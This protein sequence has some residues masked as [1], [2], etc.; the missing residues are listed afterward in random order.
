M[1]I[2]IFYGRIRS[3]LVIGGLNLIISMHLLGAE[4]KSAIPQTQSVTFQTGNRQTAL[5]ELFTSEGCSSCPP[6]EVWLSRLKDSPRLW[7]EFVPV[8]F[9]VDYWDYLGWRDQ[10]GSKAFSERQ[11]S[12]AQFWRSD[13]VYTPGFVLDGKEWQ[14][15]SNHKD[16]PP[17]PSS[18]NGVLKVTSS[19]L[20][21]WQ[22]EFSPLR[23]TKASYE[24]HAALLGSSI[25]SEVR[26]GENRG[27]RLVHDFVVLE[28]THGDLGQNGEEAKA[29]FS[30]SHDSRAGQS[31]FAIAVWVTAHGS[32]APLQAIGGW[33]PER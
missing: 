33:L 15:W 3:Q 4:P 6:A 30:L 21:R 27:R 1:R 29:E 7:K 22:V 9:H 28:I 25:T 19:D 20:H 12:Y 17:A 31:R 26:A 11:H 5:L 14:T 13:T 24:V 10:W 8:A 32:P 23:P 16:G 2:A 18:S